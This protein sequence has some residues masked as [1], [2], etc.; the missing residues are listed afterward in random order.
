[1]VRL[2]PWQWLVLA[3]PLASVVGFVLIAAGVQIQHWGLSWIWAVVIVALVGWRW[4][5]VRWLRPPAVIALEQALSDLEALPDAQPVTDDPP[6][7]A[8]RV[9]QSVIHQARNDDAPWE[10][11]GRFFGRTRELVEGVAR[12]YYPNTEHPLL[13]IYVPQAYALLRGTTDDVDRWMQSFAPIL[14]QVTVGQAYQAYRTYRRFEPAARTALQVWD[15]AQ[16]LLNPAAALARTA[17]QGQSDKANQQLLANFADILRQ[18]TLRNLGQRAIE[19]YSNAPAS[20]PLPLVSPPAAQSQSLRQILSQADPEVEARPVQVMLVGRTGAGKSSLINTLFD[21]E[22]AQVDILP[23]TDRLQDYHFQ[24]E[25]GESLILWDTP[26]YEQVG[27]GTLTAQVLD[28]IR[29]IDL[30]L[31]LTPAPDPALQMDLDFLAKVSAQNPELPVIT[32]VTQVDRLRPLRE[33]QPPYDWQ[34]GERPKEQAI[35][36]A[37]AYRAEILGEHCRSILPLVTA[38]TAKNRVA[39]GTEPLSLSLMLAVDPARQYRL[40]RFLRDLDARS[41][42]AGQIIDRYVFQMRTT[43]G[44]AALLKNPLLNLLS[45]LTTGSTLLV[46][47][48]KAQLPLEQSPAVVAKLQMAYELWALLGSASEPR[49]DWLAI[50]PLLLDNPEPIELNAWAF[51]QTLTEYWT[52]KLSVGELPGRFQHYLS[53]KADRAP[54]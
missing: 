37:I 8:Q 35:R 27:G 22:R 40:G 31:L 34:R 16:W 7:Q 18:E 23:S 24:S 26:G 51:G 29:R 2:K 21:C 19:L 20:R 52:R 43:Q 54:A 30:L 33:W 45:R 28:Q 32:V 12:V 5:L 36:E 47:L 4:L 48:L 41:C 3:L 44:L 25:A 39:W 11:W 15:W 49:F 38:D 1:M 46:E 6:A 13:N 42:A 50:W 9:I 10:D 53:Q 17:I 14:N